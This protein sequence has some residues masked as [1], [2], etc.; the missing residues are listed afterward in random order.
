MSAKSILCHIRRKFA[1]AFWRT[2][3]SCTGIAARHGR[4]LIRGL[5][6]AAI[7][8][9]IGFAFLTGRTAAILSAGSR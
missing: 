3:A 9:A 2:A 4:E 6:Y 8:C 7:I 1:I 5:L